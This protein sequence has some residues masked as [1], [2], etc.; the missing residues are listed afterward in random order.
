MVANEAASVG[1]LITEVVADL[2]APGPMV[3]AAE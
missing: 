1:G 2:V 3:R